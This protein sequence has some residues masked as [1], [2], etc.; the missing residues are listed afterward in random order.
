[1]FK[2]SF[3]SE[4][5]III[6]QTH[7]TASPSVKAHTRSACLLIF[8][9]I[10]VTEEVA[11][12]LVGFLLLWLL[13]LLLLG[14]GG[15]GSGGNGGTSAGSGNGGG[16]DVREKLL[17]VLALE[18]LGEEAGPVWLDFVAGCLDHLSELVT[19]YQYEISFPL[20]ISCYSCC[21]IPILAQD[22]L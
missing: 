9:S 4:R 17:D 16:S 8:C 2:R 5:V 3:E 19:L 21:C 6:V 15:G 10:V 22:E 18:G 1:M 20:K 7:I 11:H 14:G 13:L 12:V